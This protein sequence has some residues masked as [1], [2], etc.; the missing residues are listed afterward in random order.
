M[1]HTGKIGRLP[2]ARRNELAHRIEGGELGADIVNWLNAQP[3]IPEIL[4]AQ[5]ARRLIT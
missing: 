3:D 5:F 4:D 1:T 2:K